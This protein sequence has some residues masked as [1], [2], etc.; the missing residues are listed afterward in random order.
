MKDVPEAIPL[1]GSLRPEVVEVI[2]AVD[3]AGD[4]L[5]ARGAAAEE[6]RVGLVDA[7]VE[8]KDGAFADELGGPDDALGCEQV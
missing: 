2:V 6:R 8:R 5:Y 4:E 1:A 7:Q 3:F